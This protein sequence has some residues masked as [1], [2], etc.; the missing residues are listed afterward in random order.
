MNREISKSLNKFV[1]PLLI[2]YIASYFMGIADTAIV[3]RLSTE[4]FNAVSLL[5]STFSMIAG[6]LGSITIVLNIHL[7]KTLATEK[8]DVFYLEF[9]TSLLLSIIIGLA[10]LVAVLMYGFQHMANTIWAERRS[11]VP[12]LFLRR[13]NE[14]IYFIA[15]AAVYLWDAV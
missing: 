4:A 3:A 13:T 6:V 12:G 10:C 5:S 11:V 1:I 2:Q 15:V 8:K 7:G 9:S 14:F